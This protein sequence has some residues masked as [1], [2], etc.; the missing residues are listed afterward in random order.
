V[1]AIIAPVV[2]AV[3]ASRL[4]IFMM[5]PPEQVAGVAWRALEWSIARKGRSTMLG[6]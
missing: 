5:H 1:I 6:S 3:R 2:L 4:E